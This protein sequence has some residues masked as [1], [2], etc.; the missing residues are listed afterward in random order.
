M[1][2]KLAR[3]INGIF[4]VLGLK[5]LESQFMVSF[6]VIGLCGAILITS[7]YFSMAIDASMI[8]IAGRQRMLSQR[9]AKEALLLKY[10]LGEPSALNKTIKLFDDSH[11]VLLN[12][13]EAKGLSAVVDPVILKQLNYVGQLSNNYKQEILTY[14]SDKSNSP[15]NIYSQSTIVLKEMNKV[16][17]MMA[18][19]TNKQ[20]V[21]YQ[22]TAFVST[23]IIL[24]MIY[25][26]RL[27]GREAL[28][29]QF[30]VLKDHIDIVSKGDFTHKITDEFENEETGQAVSSY[31]L[32]LDSVSGIISGVLESSHSIINSVSQ[33]SSA[34]V[35]T[36]QGVVEQNQDIQNILQAM[37]GFNLS[38]SEVTISSNKS[39]SVANNSMQQ[40]SDGENIVSSAV[41][42]I[43]KIASKIDEAVVVINELENDSVQVGKVLEVITGIAE[44]TNLL[45]LNA[46]IEA[47]RAG[48]QGRGFAVVADEVRTLAQRTQESTEEIKAIIERL[49]GQ[50][51]SAVAVIAN[52]KSYTGESV[53][54]ANR[55]K[56]T[57]H[58]IAD[59]IASI[60]QMS[61]VIQSS[62]ENQNMASDTINNSL[63]RISNVAVQT[64][65]STNNSV[66]ATQNIQLEIQNL[67]LLISKFKV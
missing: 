63:S 24:L 51:K 40:A 11:K 4:R 26:G 65:E 3:L 30:H 8:D 35:Q 60:H 12:G 61:S 13:D 34:L 2:H 31:N 58:T 21:F 57:L 47:A 42:S 52:T 19:L 16:V 25:L 37:E 53:S 39:S 14:I 32:M 45:A 54:A 27:F 6:L 55:A 64:T 15:A 18:T 56:D 36:Q 38:M 41:I 7:Q 22:K 59:S 17:G 48:E 44:Q 50:S 23:I 62:I 49:Q 29:A 46:A 33:A 9:M 20:L 67:E 43:N 66:S 10:N 5:S 1:G 28:L